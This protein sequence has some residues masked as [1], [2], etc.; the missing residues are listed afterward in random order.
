VW[1]P[2]PLRK[3]ERKLFLTADFTIEAFYCWLI[4]KATHA[5]YGREPAET[6][7]SIDNFDQ[8]LL[9][10]V[11]RVKIVKQA[12][13]RAF[14]V[15]IP[16]YQEFTD[17]A[18]AL[19]QRGVQFVD[20]AGNSQILVSV[21]AQP[22]W[23]SSYLDAR[24]LFSSPVLTRPGTQRVVLGCDVRSLHSVLNRLRSDGVS[25]EHIYDY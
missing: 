5:T 25:I 7:A 12:G 14:V 4:E 24:L 9:Q 23:R 11:P 18:S 6:F 16:R 1:G 17:V 15:D 8:K 19:A 2:H 3:W 10:Q 20:I 21:L 13:P 22:S